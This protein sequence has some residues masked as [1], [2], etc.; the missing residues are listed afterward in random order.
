MRCLRLTNLL[1]LV[2]VLSLNACNSRDKSIV[3]GAPVAGT[4]DTVA[5]TVHL[6]N[7]GGKADTEQIAER[8]QT[9]SIEGE[10]EL[11][12]GYQIL[13]ASVAARYSESNTV[14]KSQ[15]LVA[16]PGTNMEFVLLWTEEVRSGT[17]TVEGKTGQ[18]VYHI[19]T[20]IAVELASSKDLGCGVDQPAAPATTATPEMGP[21]AEIESTTTAIR[22]QDDR[23][24]FEQAQETGTGR[25]YL[26]V[27]EWNDMPP[28]AQVQVCVYDT[29][30]GE[31]ATQGMWQN[32]GL[33]FPAHS[34]T[35]VEGKVIVMSVIWPSLET[36]T[37]NAPAEFLHPNRMNDTVRGVI[38]D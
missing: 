12:V 4:G 10:A 29:T 7:C 33:T 35:R 21:T 6:N 31:P 28:N 23:P 26:P 32:G 2:L 22:C 36:L 13:E 3:V 15:K 5:E 9:I 30:T 18:A 14:R 20:P 24:Y 19:N 11:G 37:A 16:P 27:P 38:A 1:L 25:Y 34:I 17:I 8:T